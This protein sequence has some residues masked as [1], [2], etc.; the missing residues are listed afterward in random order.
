MRGETVGAKVFHQHLLIDPSPFCES[1]AIP[2]TDKQL[3]DDLH[4]E[5]WAVRSSVHRSQYEEH[6]EALYLT[7]S[8]LQP[9]ATTAARRF[10][11]EEDGYT[12]TRVG[13]P[14]VSTMERRLAALEGT[15]SAIATAS[16]MA[17]VLLLGMGLLRAGD[18]VV[19][20]QSHGRN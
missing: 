17:A 8:F 6:S 9:D 10:S 20:S 7:S 1:M 13:N 11:M 19:C 18:H 4:P 14:T 3:P 16:G 2:M 15:E 5:T 12:Y